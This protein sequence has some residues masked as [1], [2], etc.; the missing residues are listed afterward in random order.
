MWTI[1]DVTISVEEADHDLID[2]VIT[3][4]VGRLEIMGLVSVIGRVLRIDGA[5]IG[6][7]IRRGGLNRS[8]FHVVACKI[9]RE[10]DV[11]QIVIKGGAR[12]TG[13]YRGKVPAAFRF[14]HGKGDPSC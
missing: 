5:H 12:S 10:I 13:K 4:P 11:D 8:G 6:G 2:V 3:T 1:C 14:P 7:D 9:L